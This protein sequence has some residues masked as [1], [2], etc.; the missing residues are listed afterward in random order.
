[1]S[2]DRKNSG[3]REVMTVLATELTPA[4]VHGVL[5]RH[6]L[7][8]GFDMVLDLQASVGSTRTPSYVVTCT[9]RAATCSAIRAG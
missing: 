8:D 7:V 2:V 4:D 6:L 9:P 1:M 5:R 3:Y